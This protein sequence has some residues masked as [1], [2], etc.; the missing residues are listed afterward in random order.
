[1]SRTG[2]IDVNLDGLRKLLARRAKAFAIFE[3]VQNAWDEKGVT[4]VDVN[5]KPVGGT[6]NE[7]LLTAEDD[8]PEGFRDLSHAYTLYAESEKKSNPA[9]RGMFNMGEKTVLALC[10]TVTIS[11]T[12]GTVVFDESGR[13]SKR[14]K[15]ERGT[16]FSGT[17]RLT[18]EDY[19][20]IVVATAKL[21]PPS[22]IKTTFN[23]C[24]VPPR[25]PLASFE[26][27]L[28]TMVANEDSEV[29][30]SVRKTT[31]NIYESDGDVP[32]LYEMGIPVVA[33][34]CKYHVDVQQKVPLNMERD[35]VTPAYAV[36]IKTLVLNEMH[37]H[38][39]T[40]DATTSW[41]REA[42]S[43]PDVSPEAIKDVLDKR[44]G[45]NRVAYDPSDPEA[46]NIAVTK[47]F[48]VVR[49]G[50][51]SAAEWANAKRAGAILPA[52]RVTPSPKPFSPGGDSLKLVKN[53]TEDMKR[54][55][56]FVS[57]LAPHLIGEPSIQMTFANDSQWG[58]IAC[59]EHGGAEFHINVA[60]VGHKFFADHASLRQLELI[61]H[62]FAHHE[63][64]NHLTEEYYDELTHLGAVMVRLALERPE[65]FK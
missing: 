32:T 28:L 26:A 7:Y 19:N 50:S 48:T 25:T 15:R 22:G 12:K 21:I 24:E 59:F 58:T 60:H 52:G 44:Y 27:D 64:S 20:E 11:T 41:V 17:V 8:A 30:R 6:R 34:D 33:L 47:G 9:Q 3:L 18:R 10:K 2:W 65:L 31:V 39:D 61:I 37:A 16:L 42:A 54:F 13:S 63:V 35:N 14:M 57:S 51:L 55:A 23:D 1:M 4:R 49:G 53:P 56:R 38:L 36:K 46:N 62:E 45:E 43:S 29:R 5:L 40:Q